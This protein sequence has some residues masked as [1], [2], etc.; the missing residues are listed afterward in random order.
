MSNHWIWA[1][2]FLALVISG[3][4]F[5]A[6]AGVESGLAALRLEEAH[7]SADHGGDSHQ[8]GHHEAH[9][10]VEH[11]AEAGHAKKGKLA[12]PHRDDASKEHG[13][14]RAQAKVKADPHQ[15]DPR[16]GHE[17]KPRKRKTEAEASSRVAPKPSGPR[18]TPAS[19]L[20]I[21][22]ATGRLD[23]LPTDPEP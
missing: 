20:D 9:G 1:G 2:G 4:G 11:S 22:F 13:Q 5:G 12:H 21:A 7:A 10:Q 17:E 15:Q 14:E 19:E 23:E 8:Q 6:K 18:F 3:I 16:P